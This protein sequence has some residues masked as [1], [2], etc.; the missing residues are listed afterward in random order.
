MD[1]AL[2]T[3]LRSLSA[4][5]LTATTAAE[6]GDW[7]E[8]RTCISDVCIRAERMCRQLTSIEHEL[9]GDGE[10]HTRNGPPRAT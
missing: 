2:V 1:N 10:S 7:H 5:A 4:A 3:E 9:R 6:R 8:A